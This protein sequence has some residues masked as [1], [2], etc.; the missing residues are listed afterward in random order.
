QQ[1]SLLSLLVSSTETSPTHHQ[2][3][4]KAI[5]YLPEIK[6]SSLKPFS[7]QNSITPASIFDAAWAQ[8]LSAY[9]HSPNVTFEY[10]VSG[11]DEDVP[12]V[13]DIV[14]PLINVLPYHIADVSR[15]GGPE[16][17]AHLAQ[18][19]QQQRDED[20]AHTSSNRRPTA[21]E[22]EMLRMDD[23]LRKSRDPWHFEVLIRVMHITDDDTFKP[24][25]EFDPLFFDRDGMVE[26]AEDFWGRVEAIVA[27]AVNKS[28]QVK[29]GAKLDLT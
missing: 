25:F 14:G 21:V 12:G 18:V 27:S 22:T 11:R 20:S 17:L 24:S 8:T 29:S 5:I 13:F 9:T 28:S 6:A 7:V 10:V 16:Q 15:E 2:S 1:P 4:Q 3:S 23:D 19:M 26:V